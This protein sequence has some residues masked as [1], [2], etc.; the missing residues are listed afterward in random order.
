MSASSEILEVPSSL[1]LIRLIS[2]TLFEGRSAIIVLPHPLSAISLWDRVMDREPLRSERLIDSFPAAPC[3]VSTP[4]Q[5]LAQYFGQIP[6]SLDALQDVP[7]FPD[8]L[9]LTQI[10]ALESSDRRAWLELVKSWSSATHRRTNSGKPKKSLVIIL[11]SPAYLPTTDLFLDRLFASAP[12]PIELRLLCTRFTRQSD[13]AS[14]LWREALL[15]ELAGQDAELLDILEELDD[16]SLIDLDRLKDLL[17][18][19]GERL[20]WDRELSTIGGSHLPEDP[21][22]ETLKPPWLSLWSKGIICRSGEHSWTYHSAF[23]AIQGRTDELKHRLWRGQ[24]RMLLPLLDEFR[25][26]LCDLLSHR[27]P[28]WHV[29]IQ[30]ASLNGAT[31]YPL[32]GAY[33][34]EWSELAGPLERCGRGIV[35]AADRAR[36]IRNR[37]AH[38]D[39]VT[40]HEYLEFWQHRKDA[41]FD[42]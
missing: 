22:P 14:K 26:S 42:P 28:D 35:A 23:L 24:A 38:Y 30:R 13:T 27:S 5:Q 4:I 16:E 31:T 1:T 19:Y 2:D 32:G 25:R 20:A 34:A 8:V 3:N 10:D 15:P 37:I 36:R 6:G 12:S 21:L 33:E 7:T 41:R 17:T 29:Q 9:H 11:N 18:A 40:F 39:T